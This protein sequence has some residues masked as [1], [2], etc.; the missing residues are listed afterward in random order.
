MI[1]GRGIPL[2]APA[3]LTGRIGIR[4]QDIEIVDEKPKPGMIWAFLVGFS[5][6]DKAARE[7]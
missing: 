1:L 3:K 6:I 2:N 7:C 5:P 4:P